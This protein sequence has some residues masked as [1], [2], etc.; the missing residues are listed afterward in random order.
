MNLQLINEDVLGNPL[1]G[2]VL[3]V[4]STGKKYEIDHCF[5]K[6]HNVLK[7]PNLINL[8]LKNIIKC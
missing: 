8:N 2:E 6:I 1:E 7:K 3:T 5:T 4:P